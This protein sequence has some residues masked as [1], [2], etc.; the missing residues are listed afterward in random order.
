MATV[1]GLDIGT[2]TLTGVVLSGSA[3]RY[4]LVDFFVEEVEPIGS[5]DYAEDGEYVAPLSRE[6]LLAK[7]IADRGLKDADVIV[8]VDA[9]D[10][11]IR[12]ISV[13]FTR[14]EQIRRTVFF[15][16]ENHFSGF[17]LEDSI[18]EYVK[19]GE[20]E[21]EKSRLIVAALRHELIEGRLA[22]CKQAG[23][24]PVRIDM[25]ACAL[26]NAYAASPLFDP[27]RTSLVVDMG[28]TSTKILLVEKGELRKIRSLRLETVVAPR[29]RIPEPAAVGAGGRE[30]SVE[31]VEGEAPPGFGDFSIEGRF[32]EIETALRALD[33]ATS[34]DAGSPIA[35]L[36][37]DEFD[38]VR[39]AGDDAL[40]D[41][42]LGLDVA[43]FGAA[44]LHGAPA[45]G[46]VD[47]SGN[48]ESVATEYSSRFPGQ[49]EP[50]RQF[51][52]REYLERVG[53]EIQRSFAGVRLDSPI[54]LVCLTGGM[55]DRGEA[56]RFFAE[57]FDV[58]AVALE[59]GDRI[60][61]S[62]DPS[63]AGRVGV[64]GAVAVGLA[65]EQFGGDR[66]GVD[67]RKG[68]FRYEHK[69]ER[70]KLPLLVA[71]AMLFLIFLQATFWAFH[72]W[73]QAS[74]R[75]DGITAHSRDT[76]EAFFDE[77][78][79][80]RPLPEALRLKKE[81]ES[82]GA[83]DIPRFVE[84][85]DTQASLGEVLK[86]AKLGYFEVQSVDFQFRI[87]A[88]SAGSKSS[89]KNARPDDVPEATVILVIENQEDFTKITEA[90]ASSEK[91]M[92]R[93]SG[94]VKRRG[95]GKYT[96]T[97]KLSVPPEHLKKY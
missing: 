76:F 32:V 72:E 31:V 40:D 39:D 65:L 5:G 38:R 3:K 26:F 85:A 22:L 42:G 4:R 27:A 62:L 12:E 44:S 35:I 28:T 64:Q 97:L 41:L 43:D 56:R 37:D 7:V 59:F 84:F 74:K 33:P 67:F 30:V 23:L 73:K 92:F 55:S 71:T 95:D 79:K 70:I 10:C 25:D 48:G 13:P 6:E 15:E 63:V 8:S 69:F 2:K 82:G 78:P 29:R 83:G 49:A 91:S 53:V 93:A 36:S 58:E 52:Y 17:D 88:G 34:P 81:W 45:G 77:A 87:K 1:L 96:A 86:D 50:E 51:D 16:A 68:P 14:D 54:E 80:T 19:I 24:D 89:T 18:L 47:P 21:G 94:P 9:K 11:V 66:L 90:F 46:R 60:P 20:I 75:L 61:T 57:E